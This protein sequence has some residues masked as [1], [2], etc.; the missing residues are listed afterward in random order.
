VDSGFAF[1]LLGALVLSGVFSWLQH[2]AYLRST[3][4]LADEYRGMSDA[5]LVSGRG[6]GRIRGAVVLLVIDV[7]VKKI[8]AAKAMVGSSILA[9]FHDRP[10]LL[11]SVSSA[12]D[13]AGDKHTAQAVVGAI[14]QYNAMRRKGMTR[15]AP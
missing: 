7:R 14:A 6:K 11:G 4:L 3:N 1:L 13:R 8:I 15:T 12:A 2:R 9:R 5:V 10:E